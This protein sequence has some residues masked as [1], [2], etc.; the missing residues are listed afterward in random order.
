MNKQKAPFT[1]PTVALMQPLFMPWLGYFSLIQD[2]DIFVFL[3]D[4]QFVRRSYH[5]RNRL[6]LNVG[7]ESWVTL[8]VSHNGNQKTALNNVVPMND[9]K[10]QDKFCQS[11][12]HNYKKCMHFNVFFDEIELWARQ[13]YLSVA[14]M[15]MS[16]IKR[17]SE[18][19]GIDTEFQLSSV[20]NITTSRSESMRDL[21]QITGAKTYLCAAGSYN[22]MVKDAL[23]PL[24]FCDTVFQN[25]I[26]QSYP[27]KQSNIFVPYLS[28]LDCLMQI[29]VDGTL[30]HLH[31]GDQGYKSWTEIRS[32]GTLS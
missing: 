12:L 31:K 29:G 6:F 32:E 20:Y 4:F 17:L 28:I 13:P 1:S 23:F 30:E 24:N 25:F 3:D 9:K 2:A 14:D 10:W 21:L 22:Y 16:L 19:M 7:G 27:Q 15:N 8:P 11:I 18:M 5:Q 26:P